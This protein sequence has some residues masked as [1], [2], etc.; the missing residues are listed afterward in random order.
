MWRVCFSN[1]KTWMHFA[2][3]RWKLA[4][5]NVRVPVRDV[6]GWRRCAI[7]STSCPTS[8]RCIRDEWFCDADND[9]FDNSD[10]DPALCGSRR[11]RF[12]CI[13]LCVRSYRCHTLSFERIQWRGLLFFSSIFS[14]LWWLLFSISHVLYSWV[15]NVHTL[16]CSN[17]RNVKNVFHQWLKRLKR[18]V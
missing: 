3:D 7:G 13:S 18:S 16:P 5:I 4:S 9:C 17:V 11:C 14:Y 12:F 15:W 10:E 8:D 1:A 6:D 2:D